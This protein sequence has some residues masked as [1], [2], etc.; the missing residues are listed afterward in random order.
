[1]GTILQVRFVVCARTELWIGM[2]EA[3]AETAIGTHQ[4]RNVVVY[5]DEIAKPW[6]QAVADV[7]RF[8]VYYDAGSVSRR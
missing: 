5:R 8:L 6:L 7:E 4:P 1:M 2:V 3:L